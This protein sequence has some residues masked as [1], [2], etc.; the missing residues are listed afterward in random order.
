MIGGHEVKKAEADSISRAYEGAKAAYGAWGVDTEAAMAG[1]SRIPLSLQCWQGDDVAGFE[2]R[3]GLQGAG[4]QATGNYPGRARSADE[5]R[6]DLEMALSLLPGKHRVNL[7]AMY[8][9]T[10]GKPV[11]RDALLPEHFSRWISWARGLGIALDFNQTCFSHPM[12]DS[13]FTLSSPEARV[14]EFW[15][16]HCIRSREIGLAMGRELGSPCIVNLWIHDGFKDT[17]VDRAGYRARLKESLDRVY[18]KKMDPRFVRDALEGKL[19]GIGSESFVVGSHEFYLCYALA[20]KLILT[21]DM[22]HYHPTETIADK[23]SS[24]LPFGIDLMIHVS[25]AIRWDSDHVVALTD[26]L[27]SAI[28]EVGRMKAWDRVYLG[29]DYFDASINRVAALVIGARAT[30][31][32]ALLSLLE[33]EELLRK[34]EESGDFTGRLAMMEEIKALPF[35]A[36]WDAYCLSRGVPVGIDWL[37]EVERYEKSVLLKRT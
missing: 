23:V 20:N 25:R 11:D 12:A 19:F 34:A 28:G 13:G 26:D 31:K 27:R 37:A 35:G 7:H 29:L 33:P 8:A 32:A 5:L 22:G 9:E 6:A 16:K 3:G 1:L 15:V 24:I 10:G 2:N 14:R 21:L 18:A 36:V 4:I 17:P 30:L